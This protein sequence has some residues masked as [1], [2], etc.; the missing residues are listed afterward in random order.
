MKPTYLVVIVEFR[1]ETAGAV[2]D[3]AYN[4][5]AHANAV[6]QYHF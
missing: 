2:Y 5:A 3:R 1:L 6:S 4:L